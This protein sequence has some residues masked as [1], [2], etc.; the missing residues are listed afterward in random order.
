MPT[1]C[2]S[3]Q[4]EK[5]TH[6][7][8]IYIYIYLCMHICIYTYIFIFTYIYIYTYILYES[9]MCIYVYL[10]SGLVENYDLCSSFDWND[11][12]IAGSHEQARHLKMLKRR[13]AQDFDL[14]YGIDMFVTSDL[15]S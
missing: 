2:F 15:L 10:E 14:E 3:G 5:R 4:I 13:Q 6:I 11:S 7:L 8:Y 1:F 12:Q 9:Y